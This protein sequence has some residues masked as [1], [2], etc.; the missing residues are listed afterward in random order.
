VPCQEK[1]AGFQTKKADIQD[2]QP[3]PKTKKGDI[4]DYH[5]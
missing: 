2:Y 3:R 4:Q 1:A 5:I